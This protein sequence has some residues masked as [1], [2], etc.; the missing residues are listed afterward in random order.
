[1]AKR[2]IKRG[3]T[4]GIPKRSPYAVI[5]IGTVVAAPAGA[6]RI[7]VRLPGGSQR[8]IRNVLTVK[9]V[10]L[11]RD[12]RV[13]V[14]RTHGETAWVCL[15]KVANI[16]EGGGGTA[17]D[18]TGHPVY[19]LHPPTG[20]SVTGYLDT[21]IASWTSWT[22]DG[23]CWHVQ[24]NS[25]ASASGAVDIYTYGQEVV[26]PVRDETT[27][28]FRVRAVRYNWVSAVTEYSA[29]SSWQ[30]GSTTRYTYVTGDY[31]V[32]AADYFMVVDDELGNV[33]LTLPAIAAVTGHLYKI[34]LRGIFGNT[35]TVEAAASEYIENNATY[36]LA[37]GEAIEIMSDDDVNWW[38]VSQV[39]GQ[40]DLTFSNGQDIIAGTGAGTQIGTAANQKL[41]FF[42]SAPVDQG[43]SVNDADGSLGGVT[44]Q[45][46]TLLTQLREYGLLP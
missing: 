6:S 28:Y 20:L 1:M 11:Q 16:S 24:H 3:P 39:R 2:A 29:W 23:V 4:A 14:A 32:L 21:L 46:N 38:I 30:N 43:A 42:G 8:V 41:A 40:R 34:Y 27:R 37:K 9:G 25:S 36:T 15:S 19:P 5:E 13:A 12:D 22:G 10:Q 17:V 35:V 18:S 26:Y 45:F 33:A 31:D 7:D 44:T